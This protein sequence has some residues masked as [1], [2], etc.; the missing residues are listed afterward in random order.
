MV[1]CILQRRA[2][3]CISSAAFRVLYI[4][5]STFKALF[6]QEITL[7]IML[8]Y[9]TKHGF[10][11]VQ[12]SLQI[13]SGNHYHLKRLF[14]ACWYFFPN[15]VVVVV[16]LMWGKQPP[17]KASSLLS[18]WKLSEMWV[19]RPASQGQFWSLWDSK[20]DASVTLPSFSSCTVTHLALCTVYTKQKDIQCSLVSWD[21]AQ[22]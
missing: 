12:F 9:E 3:V 19:I 4:Q 17:A 18:C 7:P 10:W 22:R 2:K 16:V 1:R 6:F 21:F 14:F 15:F 20:M 5:N 13:A 8:V 11:E